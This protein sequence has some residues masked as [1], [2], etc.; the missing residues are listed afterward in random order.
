MKN[1][2]LLILTITICLILTLVIFPFTACSQESAAPAAPAPAPSAPT[3][4]Q[5]IELNYAD[6]STETMPGSLAA[7]W[8]ASEVER[9]SGGKVK[10]NVYHNGTLGKGPELADLVQKGTVD[11][12]AIMGG[13]TPGRFP[14]QELPTQMPFMGGN[15]PAYEH[16]MDDLHL[17]GYADTELEDYHLLWYEGNNSWQLFTTKKKVQTLEDMKDMRIRTA[18]IPPILCQSLG[19][20]PVGLPMGEIYS[21]LDKGTVEGAICGIEIVVGFKLTDMIKYAFWG[22]IVFGT[23]SRLMNKAKWESLPAEAKLVLT[24]VSKDVHLVSFRYYKQAEAE[25]TD[26][27]QQAGVE[28]TRPDA[29]ELAKLKAATSGVFDDYIAQLNSKGLK[30]DE[31]KAS[32]LWL[33][34]QY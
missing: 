30:G 33:M 13:F 29:A 15:I 21:A 26:A 23:T 34:S 2:K 18:G 11:I 24:D 31:I 6:S 28:I 12:A 9:R 1:S 27:I 25:W 4:P 5:V 8:F 19:I 32:V 10:V 17:N 14:I 20:E 22:D 7:D 16:L 3:A